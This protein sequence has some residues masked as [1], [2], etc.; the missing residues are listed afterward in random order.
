MVLL[1]QVGSNTYGRLAHGGG[2]ASVRGTVAP[3]TRSVNALV[4]P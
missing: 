3:F 1:S 4:L 2:G